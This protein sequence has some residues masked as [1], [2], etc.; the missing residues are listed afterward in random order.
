VCG[1]EKLFAFLLGTYTYLKLIIAEF[2]YSPNKAGWT[3]F[4]MVGLL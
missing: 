1:R 4:V 3:P 2:Y